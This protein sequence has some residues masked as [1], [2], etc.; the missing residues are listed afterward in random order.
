[1]MTKNL[2]PCLLF[3]IGYATG[4]QVSQNNVNNNSNVNPI[5]NAITSTSTSTSL[6]SIH[7]RAHTSSRTDETI[8][9]SSTTS[10]RKLDCQHHLQGHQNRLSSTNLNYLPQDADFGE[11]FAGGQRYEMVELPDSM[12]DTTIFVGNLCEVCVYV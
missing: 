8:F 6:N 7:T 4:F 5:T 1:M 3:T 9:T 12:V 2:I 11:S 10:R